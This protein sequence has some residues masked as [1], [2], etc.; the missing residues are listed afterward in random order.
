MTEADLAVDRLLHERLRAARPDYGWMSEES[1]DDAARLEA[2][3][4]FIL[5]PI[6][7]TR[8]FAAGERT[9][10]V[11][12]AVVQDGARRGEPLAATAP[13][14]AMVPEPSRRRGWSPGWRLAAAVGAAIALN[15]LI[16]RWLVS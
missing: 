15:A 1:P 8:A 10:A 7:G 4:V 5:D 12:I 13:T 14:L 2:R 6:D 9:W 16:I 3:R 11:A